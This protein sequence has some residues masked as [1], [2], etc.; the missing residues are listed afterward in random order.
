MSAQAGLSKNLKLFLVATLIFMSLAILT[1]GQ[2]GTADAD[3]AKGMKLYDANQF[4]EAAEAFKHAVK[5]DPRNAETYYSLG[6]CYFRMYNYRE[7]V[8]AY[9]RAIELKPNHFEA[10]N[11]LGTL[12]HM[13]GDFKAAVTAY[14]EAIRIKPD[15]PQAIF[16]LGVAYLELKNKE[17][18]LEQHKMLA[19][20]DPERADKL[21]DY[22]NDKKIPLTVLNGKALSL[23]KPIYPS[24]ARAAHASGIVLVWVSIDETGKVVS[25]SALTGHPL[26]RP[27]AVEA[28]KLARFSPTI[29]NGQPVKITGVI[30]YNFV[31]DGSP[32]T[33]LPE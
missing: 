5:Q 13:L 28:A 9:K 1:R 33:P 7:G 10:Y 29:V 27:T 31:N 4:N 30:T 8:K 18:A 21:F 14:Q 17:G 25:V 23:A 24:I 3:F 19:V 32:G 16:G 6:N 22:I 26:L 15:Y 20:I 12:Y 2:Q 11:N